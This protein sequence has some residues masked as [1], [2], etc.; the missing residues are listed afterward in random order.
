[1]E[2]ETLGEGDMALSN[3]QKAR[4]RKERKQL[5]EMATFEAQRRRNEI[6]NYLLE[7]HPQFN[8]QKLIADIIHET[9]NDLMDEGIISRSMSKKLCSAALNKVRQRLLLTDE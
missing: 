9:F 5:Q 6:R 1:M 4:L 3:K 2:S 7:N 8:E